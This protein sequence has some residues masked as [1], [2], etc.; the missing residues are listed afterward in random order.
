MLALLTTLTLIESERGHDNETRD[1]SSRQ[2]HQHAQG[3]E[4]R[5]WRWKREGNEAHEQGHNDFRGQRKDFLEIRGRLLCSGMYFSF[6]CLPCQDD[7]TA[8]KLVQAIR[9]RLSEMQYNFP[10]TYVHL[11]QIV[12]AELT[13][14]WT[15]EVTE[16]SLV[17]QH[18]LCS[19]VFS[20]SGS[21]IA[22]LVWIPSI[23]WYNTPRVS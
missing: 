6:V 13:K 4:K 9:Q 23:S 2:I 17:C 5:A 16:E 11:T 21:E 15:N 18:I 1:P 3:E 10:Y 12:K 19:D 20:L 7:R 8:S 14:E 22:P